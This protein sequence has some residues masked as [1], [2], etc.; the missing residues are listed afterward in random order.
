MRLRES[1]LERT[2]DARWHAI[3]LVSYEW[4]RRDD[5]DDDAEGCLPLHD[6]SVATTRVSV[7]VLVLA[8]FMLE[9]SDTSRTGD[10]GEE[11][12][13]WRVFKARLMAEKTRRYSE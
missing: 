2:D 10:A 11:E 8:A 7:L 13:P 3:G 4:T 1:L 12:E 6:D 9:D 5:D